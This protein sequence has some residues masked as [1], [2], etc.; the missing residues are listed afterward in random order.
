MDLSTILIIALAAIFAL[1]FAFFQYRYR[2]KRRGKDI[3]ILFALRFL[4]VFVLFLLL[5]NPKITSTTYEL[6]KPDL[7]LAVDDSESIMHL[8]QGN[9]VQ[10]LLQRLKEDDAIQE[11]FEVFQY[12][13][14]NELLNSN[15]A[16]F[17]ARQTN[18]NSALESFKEL[19][20]RKSAAVVLISDGNQTTG[21]DFRY[22]KPGSSQQIYP[23]VV[24]DTTQYLDLEVLRL[25]TNT[26]AFLN[27]RFPVEAFVSY[28]GEEPVNSRFLIKSGEKVVFS[29]D[30]SLDSDNRSLLIQTELPASSLGVLSYEAEIVKLDNEKNTANNSRSF[31]VEVI[32][33]RSK[34][35]LI[36]AIP[37]PDIGTFKKSIETNEQRQLDIKYVGDDLTN[38]REYQLIILYQ[39][40]S[41]FT[42]IFEDLQENNQNYLLISG[43]ETDWNFVNSIQD[44]V[45]KDFSNQPQEI[46]ATKNP[47]FNQFQFEEVGFNNFP[48]LEDTF[49]E[50][51][52]QSNDF[53]SIYFQQIENVETNQPLIAIQGEG[54]GKNAFIFGEN[55]W[56]W[57]A[58]TYLQDKSFENFDNFI[59]KLV[60]N[61]AS[62]RQR[63]R[64]TINY[65]SFY[66]E[67]EFIKLMANYF[68]QN[69]QFDSNASLEIFAKNSEESIES[70]LVLKN[71]G[72]EVNLGNLNPGTYNFKIFEANSDISRSGSFEVIPFNIEQQFIGAN[73]NAMTVLAEN[74][75]TALFYP[76]KLQELKNELLSN[77]K[78]KPVQKSQ[79]KN[80]PLIDWYYL[81]FLLVS[82]LAAEW[83]FRKYKGLI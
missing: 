26:Y 34:I 15:T 47:N 8:E 65:K 9:T 27:N 11:R 71:N 54:Q 35:L 39:P 41:A 56:R 2:S 59:G 45:R 66:Y 37:H 74:S 14:G 73:K 6:E 62:A 33:E 48:P 32:D 3:Y 13:F 23:L 61:L 49:G 29:E 4:S 42:S 64:L 78:Y 22:F 51:S 83:F 24:G 17:K 50:I 75:G 72:Y 25:N 80:V 58:A 67:N 36:S 44:A 79:Q 28:S 52:I 68:D 30:V 10:E 63:E 76:D 19:S 60:Q 7:I 20:R 81:L 38:L 77:D 46:F 21:R 18:I 57:R 43:T 82:I 70:E 69:Y 40:N 12:N 31:A 1:G 55:I 5:I 53:E 16:E